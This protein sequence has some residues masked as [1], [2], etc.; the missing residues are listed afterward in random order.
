MRFGKGWD[1]FASEESINL[2]NIDPIV[3]AVKHKSLLKEKQDARHRMEWLKNRRI[4]QSQNL[5]RRKAE[6][7]TVE[8]Y[9]QTPFRAAKGLKHGIDVIST[10]FHEIDAKMTHAKKIHADKVLGKFAD[11]MRTNMLRVSDLIDRVD[12]SCDGVVDIEELTAAIKMVKLDLSEEDIHVLMDFLDSSGDGHIDAKELEDAMRDYR[13]V[14]YERNSLMSY[15]ELT[16][17]TKQLPLL[18]ADKVIDTRL[19]S[20]GIKGKKRQMN[21]MPQLG[22]HLINKNYEAEFGHHLFAP[23]TL[24]SDS[25]ESSLMSASMKIH[26]PIEIPKAAVHLQAE[27]AIHDSNVLDRTAEQEYAQN[28]ISRRGNQREMV[29]RR[30]AQREL[31]ETKSGQRAEDSMQK[32]TAFYEG[33]YGEIDITIKEATNIEMADANGTD[34]VCKVHFGEVVH[35]TSVQWNTLHP[36]W[37]DTFRFGIHKP[38]ELTQSI[39]VELYDQ[40]PHCQEFLGETYVRVS[41]LEPMRNVEIAVELQKASTGSMFMSVMF[42]PV[43]ILIERKAEEFAAA[44][45]KLAG[46]KSKHLEE[47]DK[48]KL[49]RENTMSRGNSTKNLKRKGSSRSMSQSG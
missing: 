42:V 18:S 29:A 3:N 14:H 16:S 33:F 19:L 25:F 9:T 7:E 5:A 35:E 4:E 15:I 2:S 21:S 23:P 39:K 22:Q 36:I 46:K 10:R 37:N 38:E 1:Q 24:N 20:V 47:A 8:N 45:N 28:I 11:F 31:L 40:D 43:E 34:G 32:A 41:A 17:L 49:K 30:K 48:A 44:K 6:R 26:E 12:T 13:R 27:V